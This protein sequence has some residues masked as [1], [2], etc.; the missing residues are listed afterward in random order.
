MAYIIYIFGSQFP[1]YHTI[2]S[3]CPIQTQEKI[4]KK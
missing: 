2:N 4:F 3:V 1:I